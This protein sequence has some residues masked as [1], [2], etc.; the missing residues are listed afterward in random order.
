MSHEG[1][2]ITW[3]VQGHE[4]VYMGIKGKQLK[5]KWEDLERHEMGID[6]IREGWKAIAQT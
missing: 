2:S 6:E 4:M 5:W 1:W 3:L